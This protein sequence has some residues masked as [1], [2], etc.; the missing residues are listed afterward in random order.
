MKMG[1]MWLNINSKTIKITNLY[2]KDWVQL[3]G[4]IMIKNTKIAVGLYYNGC[5]IVKQ[6]F[7]E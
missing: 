5:K 6:G 1:P 3:D 7:F 4:L 2:S